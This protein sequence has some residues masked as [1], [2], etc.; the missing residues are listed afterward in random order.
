MRDVK[1]NH[2]SRDIFISAAGRLFAEKG[3]DAVSIRDIASE[4]NID[5]SMIKYHFGNKDGLIKAVIARAVKP[6]QANDLSSYLQEN[7]SLLK[8]RDGQIIFITGMV[9]LM[10]KRFSSADEESWCKGFILQFIQKNHP[11]R[12]EIIDLYMKPSVMAFCKIYRNITGNDD[13]E[14]AFCWYLFILCPIYMYSGANDMISLFHPNG[15]M[16]ASF[17]RRMLM[18]C[19]QQILSGFKLQ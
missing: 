4:A 18:F 1:S 7:E 2:S 16:T 3:T 9:E 14:S 5:S 17:Q 6:W 13:F 19:T 11:L 15:Q 10:H 8:T 12:Q